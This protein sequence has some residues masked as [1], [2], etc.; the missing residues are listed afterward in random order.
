[1][2]KRDV[3]TIKILLSIGGNVGHKLLGCFACFFG[4][5]HD[6]GTMGVIGTHKVNRMAAHALKAHPNVSLDVF[7]H[8]PNMKGG[9][10][11]GE[12]SGYKKL[13]R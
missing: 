9:I 5:D 2:V 3:K 11:V 8:V 10:G 1:V 4:T 13:A 6:R 12:G 7:H